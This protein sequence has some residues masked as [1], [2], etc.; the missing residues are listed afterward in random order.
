MGW[1]YK[2]EGGLNCVEDAFS[3]AGTV[4]CVGL[5]LED[6]EDAGEEERDGEHHDSCGVVYEFIFVID[7]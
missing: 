1:V 6:A 2:E 4:F 7:R 3:P 5:F